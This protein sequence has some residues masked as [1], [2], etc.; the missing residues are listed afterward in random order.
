[1]PV[2]GGN[3]NSSFANGLYSL[4]DPNRI[5]QPYQHN[6]L[7][8]SSSVARDSFLSPPRQTSYHQNQQQ[9]SY[10]GSNYPSSHHNPNESMLAFQQSRSRSLDANMYYDAHPGLKTPSFFTHINY[11]IVYSCHKSTFVVVFE[12]ICINLCLK[13]CKITI[14]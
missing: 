4:N 2:G 3:N 12:K 13:T 6:L 9:Q 14:S 7:N 5:V 1:M 10:A 8:Q 11:K